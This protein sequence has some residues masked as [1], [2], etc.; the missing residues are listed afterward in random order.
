[1]PRKKRSLTTRYYSFEGSP[2]RVH[3][4]ELRDLTGDVYRRGRGIVPADATYIYHHSFSI[5]RA[6]YDELVREE[7]RFE[8]PN[9]PTSNTTAQARA[10]KR[11]L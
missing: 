5:T 1:M 9:P 10:F 2:A 8:A 4:D 3:E 11:A 6:R 7:K